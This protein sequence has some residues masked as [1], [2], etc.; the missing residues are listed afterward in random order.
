MY[1][2]YLKRLF[3]III[4]I[5]AMPLVIPIIF[6]FSILIIIDDGFPIFY[7]SSRRG[8]L[9]STF[10]MHKLRSMKKNSPDIRLGDGST[11]NSYT[12]TR[13]TKIGKIIRKLSIDE[14]PQLFNVLIGDMSLV[15]PRP[16]LVSQNYN[17]LDLERKKRLLVKPGITGFSQAYF[18]NSISQAEKI[19]HD[20][21][22]VENVSFILDIK[23]I[24]RTIYSILNKKDIYNNERNQ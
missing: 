22:Y 17:T 7:S 10:K 2:K 20:C 5:I 3:D 14:L 24:F 16:S 9:G 15:G 4:S 21:W 6:I 18:R 13:V 8:Q 1:R 19:T 12:D 23:I 11:Y